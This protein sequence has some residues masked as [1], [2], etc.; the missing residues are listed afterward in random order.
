MIV[1]V[2][3]D[4]PTVKNLVSGVSKVLLGFHDP[5]FAISLFPRTNK[6]TSFSALIPWGSTS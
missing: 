3:I 2:G 1:V 6:P 4:D 5:P